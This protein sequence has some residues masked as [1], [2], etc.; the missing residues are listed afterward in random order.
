MSTSR[1]QGF[2]LV[3]VLLSLVVLSLIIAPLY[4]AFSGS[5]RHMTA[6][7]DQSIAVS[8]A[9]SYMAALRTL[10]PRLLPDQRFTRDLDLTG[11]LALNQLGIATGPAGFERSVS[12]LR[13]D[14]ENREGGP[15]L[16]AE[17]LIRWKKGVSSYLL[18]GLLRGHP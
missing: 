5:R 18:Q 9:A 3:E 6:A 2:S 1:S 16:Q 7:R 14:A 10:D 8:L 12:L 4:L 15:Y 17:I 13:V 11:P